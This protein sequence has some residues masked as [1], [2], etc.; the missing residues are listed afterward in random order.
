[1]NKDVPWR[2]GREEIPKLLQVFIKAIIELG[3]VVLDAYLHVI[4]DLNA[5]HSYLIGHCQCFMC[6]MIDSCVVSRCFYSCV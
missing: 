4:I 5:N 6:L 3:D 2:D 1:M